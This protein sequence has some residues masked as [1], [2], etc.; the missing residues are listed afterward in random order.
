LK[1]RNGVRKPCQHAP[2]IKSSQALAGKA[3]RALLPKA[4]AH[5]SC[6]VLPATGG[7]SAVVLRCRRSRK[8]A[9]VLPVATGL[10]VS[11]VFTGRS[12][13][14]TVNATARR[15]RKGDWCAT[16][17]RCTIRLTEIMPCPWKDPCRSWSRRESATC[18]TPGKRRDW[19]KD[20][21]GGDAARPLRLPEAGRLRTH[22]RA[23][24]TLL[25]GGEEKQPLRAGV[26]AGRG[27]KIAHH[28]AAAA[29]ARI[30]HVGW[31][32]VSPWWDGASHA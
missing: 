28:Q 13:L 15:G 20:W 16:D 1:R 25:P 30:I 14:A 18:R 7:A 12:L 11:L 21:S 17:S 22:G 3:L 5:N 29:L 8:A 23:K 26:L 27:L 19:W 32:R 31:G 9:E 10:E 6:L 24:S 2:R 4:S